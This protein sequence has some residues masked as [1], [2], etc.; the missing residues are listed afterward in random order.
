MKH[1]YILGALALVASLQATAAPL[2]IDPAQSSVSV[3]FKQV[4]VPVEA[5][6][7]RFDAMLDFDAAKIGTSKA[8]IDIDTASLDVGEAESNKEVAKKEWFNVAQFPKATFVTSS[9]RFA[10]RHSVSERAN[11]AIPRSWLTR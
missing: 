9:I 11:G 1:H 4:S 7:R 8:R 2:K 6:F 5:K 10:V 3:V